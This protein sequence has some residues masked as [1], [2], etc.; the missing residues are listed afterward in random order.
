MKIVAISDTHNRHNKLVIPPCDIL[1]H[2]GDWT[3]MGYKSEVEDF[4]KW[5]NKQE[6]GYIIV[7][8]GNHEKYLEDNLP[9]SLEW[10]VDHCP[11]AHLL[12]DESIEI[13][14]IKIHGSPV[15][16]WFHDWAWNRSSNQINGYSV[17]GKD[18]FPLPIKPH[19]DKIPDDVNILITHGPPYGILDETTYAN[20]DPR[21]G[22]L[23]CVEL[24]NRIKELKDLDLH[25][26]GHI[27]APGGTEKH[28]DGVS[29]YNAAICDESYFP[30]NKI[31]EVDYELEKKP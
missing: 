27:H 12:I 10:F 23:G 14:G 26:F 18:F 25:F 30:G 7:V 4:A 19:W 16:P 3:S 22:H 17:R 5:I 21:P 31:T 29:Y 9:D 8:P 6:A 15:S 28:I 20:G 13:E 2:C 24:M 1:I 11:T